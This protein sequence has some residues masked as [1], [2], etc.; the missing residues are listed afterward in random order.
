MA[1]PGRTL[2]IERAIKKLAEV[3]ELLRTV[4][5]REA[6]SSVRSLVTS[7]A[8][9][10]LHE[11]E[12]ELRRTIQLFHPKRRRELQDLL[13]RA[14]TAAPPPATATESNVPSEPMVIRED[15]PAM[16]EA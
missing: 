5:P 4:R 8:D 10:E 1:N 14:L 2:P 3:R 16:V 9:S 15:T 7:L 11:L 13:R 12:G 6:E